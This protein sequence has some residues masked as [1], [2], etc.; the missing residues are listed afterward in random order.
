MTILRLNSYVINCKIILAIPD[1]NNQWRRLMDFNLKCIDEQSLTTLNQTIPFPV[2]IFNQDGP[3]YFDK[4]VELMFCSENYNISYVDIYHSF[5]DAYKPK[6]VEL[7]L[8]NPKLEKIWLSTIGELVEYQGKTAVIVYI[9]EKIDKILNDGEILRLSKLR[10]YMLEINQSIV[11]VTD[12]KRT[13]YLILSNALKAL[14]NAS[15]GS[16]FIKNNDVFEVVSYIGFDKSIEEF[17]L[18]V[19]DSFLYRNTEGKMDRISNIKRIEMDDQFYPVKTYAGDEVYIKSEISAPIYINGEMYGIINLDSLNENA[20][21]ENDYASMEFISTNVQIAI[22][23]QL[24]YIEKSRLAMFDPLTKL[25]NRHYFEEQFLVYK[26]RAS[27][28]EEEFHLVLFDVDD[29]KIVND[30]YGHNVGD[31]VIKRIATEIQSY[32]RN[33][34]VIA[35]YGGD[36]FIGLFIGSSFDDLH[37]KIQQIELEINKNPMS[38]NGNTVYSNFSFGIATFPIDGESLGELLEVADKRMY[39]DKENKNSNV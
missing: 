34:D 17:K 4:K 18:P 9:I 1:I 33:S 3:L 23:N 16:I 28:Y 37:N 39:E 36:E 12:L 14:E 21:D 7:I 26:R 29:L 35:R 2:L 27:R 8:L 25:Y 38:I 19:V 10:Q 22:S 30:L 31:L 20:F 5:H 6:R 13:F 11:N 15:L 24:S 32:T